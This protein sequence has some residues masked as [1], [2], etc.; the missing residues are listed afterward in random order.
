MNKRTALL[1]TLIVFALSTLCHPSLY[2]QKLPDIKFEKF[3]LP[4]GLQVILHEDHSVPTVSVNVWYHVGSKNEKRGRTGFAHLFEHLM[5]EGSEHVAEGLFDKWLEAAGGTDNGSTT[6]DRTNYWETVPSNALELALYLESDRLANLLAAIDQKKLDTQRDVVKNERREG[7]DNQPYGRVDEV[8]SEAL[9]PQNHPYS[10]KVIG[11][12]EDLS[13]ASLEDVKDFFRSYYTPSDAS[14]CVAGDIDPKSTRALVEKYFSGIPPGPPVERI[15]EWIPALDGL[16]RIGMRDN[17]SLPRIY[18]VW[19]TPPLYQPD[20]AELDVLASIMSTGKNSRLYKS[21]VYEQQIAQDVQAYQASKEIASA[22]YIIATAKPGI[23][24]SELEKAIDAELGDIQKD[25]PEAMEVTTA[26][27]SWEASFVRRLQSVGGFG[28]KADKLNQYNVFVG[29]PDYLSEDLDRY[30]KITPEAVQKA[31]QKYLDLNKRLI[32]SVEPAGDLKTG[33]AASVDRTRIPGSGPSPKFIPPSFEER[34]LSNGLKVIIAEHHELP[35]VQLNLI[36]NAGWTADPDHKPGVSSLTSDLQ[37]EGTKSRTALEISQELK[38]LGA[39]LSTSSSFD[40]SSVSLNTL[41]KHLPSS[42]DIFADVLVNP[43][44][45]EMELERIKKEYQARILQEKKEPDTA[46][47]KNFLRTLYGQ[48]HPYGQPYTGSGT[49]ESI[50]AITGKDL[51]QFYEIHFHPN[52]ATLIVVGDVKTDEILPVLEKALKNW[53]KQDVPPVN[54]PKAKQIENNH[55]YLIDKPGA[56]Q[57]VIVTG[58]FGLLRNS[59]DYYRAEV[60]NTILG[61]KFTSRLNMNLR[62]DKGYTYGAF[63]QFM[64]LKDIGSFMA[65]T[66]VDTQYTKETLVEM[67]KEYRGLAGSIPVSNEELSETKKYMTLSYPGEFETISQIADR[68]GEMVTYNLPKDYFHK[69]V[70]ALEGVS[71]S[72]VMEASKRYIRPDNMLFVIMGDIKKIEQGV[73][74]LKLG[75][76]HYLDLDENPIKK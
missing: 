53:R 47:I 62:E 21:L 63:S 51:K 19:P 73:R 67:L 11:S 23:A 40:T 38:A 36:V 56:P 37:D 52:N 75:E 7:V 16:K 26:V 14:L 31:A 48:D 9:Y 27:N 4:N 29:R 60:M 6:E 49:E 70:P 42:L 65:F 20:D 45:A 18:M 74:D 46:S 61:G 13:A 39:S 57:S 12:M 55:I 44:F 64:Y 59:P 25:Q 71:A 17:V 5:F 32:L 54:I 2:S 22:F 72:D 10:W 8:V 34:I 41:K 15:E 30:L 68:L 43:A 1:M 66:Q 35:L 69:H 58:H 33:E 50:K 24:L 3:T 76:I 28:G